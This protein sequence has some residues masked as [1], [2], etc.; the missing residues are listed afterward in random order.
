MAFGMFVFGL[1][2]S[3]LAVVQESIIVRFFRGHNLG[4]SMAIGLVVGK[5]AS[6]V[7]ART[8]FALA[9]TFGRHAPFYVATSLALFSFVVNL[10]Y[11]WVSR[12]LIEETGTELEA[13]EMER[14]ARR[15][16]VYDAMEAEALERIALKRR[17][18]LTDLLEMDSVFW[19]YVGLN[20]LCGAIWAPFTHLAA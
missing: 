19:V 18:H 5:A 15:V 14:E 3:P 16:S 1:G 9:D 20:V 8:S 6:Y 4:T 2:I 13:S 10:V 7:S 12:W 17:V 11:L